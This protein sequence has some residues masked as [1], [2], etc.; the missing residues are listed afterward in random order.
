M[1]KNNSVLP[2]N[3]VNIFLAL[4]KMH[5]EAKKQ[6]TTFKGRGMVRP[7]ICKKSHRQNLGTLP[8]QQL[9]WVGTVWPQYHKPSGSEARCGSSSS[10]LNLCK[11]D[12]SDSDCSY[13]FLFKASKKLWFTVCSRLLTLNSKNMD[14]PKKPG[15]NMFIHFPTK[16]FL[17][18]SQPKA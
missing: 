7:R 1:Q 13:L 18:K 8:T 15:Q 6:K 3:V 5:P 12:V 14:L 17:E 9:A 4:P 2:V 16:A 10:L 11:I